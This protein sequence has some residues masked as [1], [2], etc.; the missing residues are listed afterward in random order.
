MQGKFYW[1][2]VLDMGI[3]ILY[4]WDKQKGKL[5]NRDKNKFCLLKER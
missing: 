3:T 1:K 4:T 5:I 2:K